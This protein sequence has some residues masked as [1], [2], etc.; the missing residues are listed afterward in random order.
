MFIQRG[1]FPILVG[2]LDTLKF[3]IYHTLPAIDTA[4]HVIL[5]DVLL[6]S[7]VEDEKLDGI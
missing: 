4:I 2:H 1:V 3:A 5:H 7:P 6:G